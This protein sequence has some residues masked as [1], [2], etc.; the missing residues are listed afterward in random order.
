MKLTL[1][2]PLFSLYYS[3]HTEW[4]GVVPPRFAHLHLH[5][6]HIGRTLTANMKRFI[7]PV[8][9]FT[10]SLCWSNV[11]HPISFIDKMTKT[12]SI[13]ANHLDLAIDCWPA[14]RSVK[15]EAADRLLS[16]LSFPLAV[17]DAN[18]VRHLLPPY[19]RCDCYFLINI[20]YFQKV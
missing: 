18:I 15:V 3:I 2:A 19:S 12:W 16:Y 6:P 17:I 5:G 8:V 9:Y 11:C 20:S 13:Y 1:R 7:E 4:C 14:A 10:L